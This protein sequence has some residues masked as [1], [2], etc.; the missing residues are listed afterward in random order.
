MQDS[1]R[2]ARDLRRQHNLDLIRRMRNGEPLNSIDSKASW[3]PPRPMIEKDRQEMARLYGNAIS[4]VA[5]R[6][7]AKKKSDKV[8]QLTTIAPAP[9]PNGNAP[10]DEAG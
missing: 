2:N 8:V 6:G 10:L 7:T 1:K 3:Y 9:E 4:T 5:P